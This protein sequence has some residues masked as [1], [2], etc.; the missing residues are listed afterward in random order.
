VKAFIILVIVVLVGVGFVQGLQALKARNDF[1]ERVH[2][3]LDFVSDTT[4]D[5]VK[6][7]LVDEAKKFNIDL[8]VTGIDIAYEDTQQQTVAQGIV[9]GRLGVQFVNK[10]VEI[11]AAITQHVLGIPIHS[12]VIES[13][14]RQVEA[15]RREPSPEMKQ[16]LEGNP[17]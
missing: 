15:P 10:R 13:H 4:M 3:Q 9:G 17:Q 14:I 1:A 8:A 6:Q 5:S 16:L 7:E 11:D 12:T 2:H